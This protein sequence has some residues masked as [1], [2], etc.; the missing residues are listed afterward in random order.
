[1]FYGLSVDMVIELKMISTIKANASMAPYK[2]STKDPLIGLS[3][4]WQVFHLK[5]ESIKVIFF[6]Y[7]L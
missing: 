6:V 7:H 3:K 5:L 2:S 4:T 1:V